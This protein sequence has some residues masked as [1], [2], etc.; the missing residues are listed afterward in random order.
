MRNS[1]TWRHALFLCIHFN[2]KMAKKEP[3]YINIYGPDAEYVYIGYR[4]PGA[5]PVKH[6]Y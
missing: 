4:L 5:G 3:T 2:L 1:D 6:L